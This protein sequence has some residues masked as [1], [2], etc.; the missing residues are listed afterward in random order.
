MDFEDYDTV[1]KSYPEDKL[2]YKFTTGTVKEPQIYVRKNYA[3]LNDNFF[4]IGSSESKE[5][6][7]L[8]SS[9]YDSENDVTGFTYAR[10]TLRMEAREDTYERTVF[11]VFDFTGLIGGVFEIFEII[12]GI[13]VGY[14]SSKLFLFSMLTNLYQVQKIDHNDTTEQEFTKVLPKTRKISIKTNKKRFNEE[15]KVPIS[16]IKHTKDK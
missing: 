7:S 9:D 16:K 1:I 6:Y 15:S 8:G 3:S 10:I 14:F 4:Q 2:A 13:F 11:S 12:G 5:F